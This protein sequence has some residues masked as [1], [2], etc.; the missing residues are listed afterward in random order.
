MAHK[1]N[2]SPIQQ[3]HHWFDVVRE[4]TLL[5]SGDGVIQAANEAFCKLVGHRDV[6]D[7]GFAE[8]AFAPS[9]AVDRYIEACSAS[10]EAVEGSFILT[11]TQGVLIS[12]RCEGADVEWP[13]QP[14]TGYVL[15]RLVPTNQVVR[16]E[17]APPPPE[18]VSADHGSL[19]CQLRRSDERL[20]LVLEAGPMAIWEWNAGTKEMIASPGLQAARGRGYGTYRGT[21]E[22]FQQDIHPEDRPRVVESIRKLMENG[23]KHQVEYRLIGPDGNCRWI[24]DRGS[25][26]YDDLGRPTGVV[27]IS[28][29]IDQRKELERELETR[30][31]RLAHTEAQIRSVIETATDGIVTIDEKG[32]ILNANPAAE[33]IF[34]YTRE[35]L[36]GRNVSMLMP[37]PYRGQHDRYMANY[38]RTGQSRVIGVQR[39]MAGQRKNG[40]VFPLELGM[41]EARLEGRRYFTAMMRDIT[42]RK[43]VEN[44]A[45][46]MADASRSLATLVGY[47]GA[48]QQVAYLAVPFFADWCTVHVGYEDGS[49]RQL[50]AAHVDPDKAE[51]AQELGNGCSLAL[52]SAI[53]PAQVFTSGRS[54]LLDEIPDALLESVAEDEKHRN[55]LRSL[56]LRS[57]MGIPLALRGNV[58]GVISFFSADPNRCYDMMDL[59]MAE[60]LAH[61]T[62]VAVENG[63]LFGLFVRPNQPSGGIPG[64]GSLGRTLA[65]CL[66]EKYAA[67]KSLPMGGE[68]IGAES[69]PRPSVQRGG[70]TLGTSEETPV[71]AKGRRILVV[72]DNVGTAKILSRLLAKLGNHEVHVV[73]DGVTALN[74]AAKH[75]PEI[76]LLDIGLPRMNGY[77]V[78]RRLRQQPDFQDTLLIALTGYETE[79]DRRRAVAAGFDQR[80]VKPASI[81][82]LR[83]VLAH[84][85]LFAP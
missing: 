55:V 21:L 17:Q 4:P 79:E 67:T 12:C 16:Q 7:S 3:F 48:L 85:K 32:S 13:S 42:E 36:I 33:R 37:E 72:E 63:L 44:V 64:K 74:A 47:G 29:P 50:T 52:E 43:R 58:F 53:G 54:E 83:Q 78:A 31:I 62:S 20:R 84:P 51:V 24:E 30:L 28:I 22:A 77:E 9:D 82:H 8:F 2:P 6:V 73:H 68:D 34:G 60:D 45:H 26:V 1:S 65:Q 41:S 80:I 35:E 75:H 81:D 69:A 19:E 23:S 11:D 10:R 27:C 18:T 46:F 39:E 38:L 57:Y 61:R 76:V 15:L 71:V 70:A 56:G 59:G 66:V 40:V 25:P 14:G 5:L 49:L